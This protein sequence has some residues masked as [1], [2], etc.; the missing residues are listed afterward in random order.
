MD[1]FPKEARAPIDSVNR[2]KKGNEDPF[3]SELPFSK[4][5]FRPKRMRNLSFD[6]Q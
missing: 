3:G 2:N 6:N 4:I 5:S 1:V